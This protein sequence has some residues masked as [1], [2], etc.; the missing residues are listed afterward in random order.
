MN[1][2]TR[3][4]KIAEEAW[5]NS[6]HRRS[7]TKR[8]CERCFEEWKRNGRKEEEKPP[9]FPPDYEGKCPTCGSE[10]SRPIVPL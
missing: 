7:V 3:A 9:F 2:L 4:W 5:K 6:K 10:L 8:Q 1:E